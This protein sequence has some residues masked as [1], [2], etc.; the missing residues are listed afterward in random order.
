MYS[1]SNIFQVLDR[2]HKC[3]YFVISQNRAIN[4]SNRT[5]CVPQLGTGRKR[6]RRI[7]VTAQYNDYNMYRF[8]EMSSLNS[9][10][11]RVGLR[12]IILIR[13]QTSISSWTAFFCQIIRLPHLITLMTEMKRGMEEV[14]SCPGRFRLSPVTDSEIPTLLNVFSCSTELLPWYFFR[15]Y[16]QIPR[17]KLRVW[18]IRFWRIIRLHGRAEA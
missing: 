7:P 5:D 3:K 17:S 14:L 18:F 10:E 15:F 2:V 1:R 16:L 9:F 11:L 4:L 13:N 12:I 6:A 8:K